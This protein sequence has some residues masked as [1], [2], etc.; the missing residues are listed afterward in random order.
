L[1]FTE[2]ECKQMDETPRFDVLSGGAW[3]RRRLLK[4]A[5]GAGAVALTPAFLAACGG[6]GSTSTGASGGGGAT[7]EVG[8]TLNY[9]GW[10]AE[11][12][13]QLLA[14][15]KK[16]NGVTI[17]STFIGNMS[18][19]AAKYAAGGGGE[20][21]IICMSSNGT[22][23]LLGSGVPFMPLDLEQL[24]NYDGLIDFFKRDPDKTFQNENGDVVAIPITYG[25]IGI[26]YDTTKS[27][28]PQKWTDLLD[29]KYKGQITILDDPSTAFGT[30]SAIL[31]F[32]SNEMTKDQLEETKKWLAQF[33]AQAKSFAPSFGDMSTQIAQGEVL[34]AMFGMTSDNAFAAEA[35]NKNIETVFEFP[36]G[37]A[38][39]TEC[40]CIPEDGS[41]PATAYSMIN[42]LL[43]PK[44]NAEAANL[45][46]LG[47]A[48]EKAVPLVN[49][50][51]KPLFPSQTKD[52][53]KFLESSPMVQDAPA[54]SDEFVTFGEVTQA[55]TEVKGA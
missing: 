25:A 14:P 1:Q 44:N 33:V 35:G 36:E 39:F 3:T 15:W 38:S 10:Q 11:D 24:P 37:S 21:D 6:G 51:V 12:Y 54:Q 22:S 5:A 27:E 7:G 47:P 55:W 48:V 45:V 34:A 8:G 52:I 40:Y 31:G 30:A 18:D 17:K 42:E 16:K 9:L 26:N 50:T 49:S 28:P 13:Q 23:R 20:Y 19:I 32:T 2:E 53:E 43:A 4:S 29:P 41:N 46:V